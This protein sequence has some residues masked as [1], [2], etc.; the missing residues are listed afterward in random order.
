MRKRYI[1]VDGELVEYG[2]RGIVNAP[3]I[4]PDIAPY[5]SMI[6]GSII[7]SRSEHREHL[8]KHN[9]VEVGNEVNHLKAYD[10]LGDVAPQQRHEIIRAQV[11]AIRHEDWKRMVK[12]DLDGIRWNSRN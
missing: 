7:S 10:N 12:R 3:M 11:D 4:Q 5:R 8:K 2:E 9:C 6:D 1:Q